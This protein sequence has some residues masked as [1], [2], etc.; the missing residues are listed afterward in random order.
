MPKAPEWVI[1]FGK[2]RGQR[3]SQVPEEYLMWLRDSSEDKIRK[4]DNELARRRALEEA[5]MSLAERL[6]AEGYRSMAKKAHPDAGGDPDEFRRLTSARAA[7]VE[8]TRKV[9]S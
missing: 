3:A 1:E 4:V 7:L 5:S 9:L 8:I 6:I 2:H